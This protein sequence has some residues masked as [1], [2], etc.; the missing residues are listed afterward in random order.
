MFWP[1]KNPGCSK[2]WWQRRIVLG[3]FLRWTGLPYVYFLTP[4]IHLLISFNLLL[5]KFIIHLSFEPSH[6]FF[7]IINKKASHDALIFELR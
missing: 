5:M 2:C 1:E 4:E 6:I 3:I 7:N